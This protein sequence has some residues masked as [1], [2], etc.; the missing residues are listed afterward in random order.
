MGRFWK[1]LLFLIILGIL[2]FVGYAY[3]GDLSPDQEDIST[4]VEIDAG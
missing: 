1:F 3:F 4:P 2:A